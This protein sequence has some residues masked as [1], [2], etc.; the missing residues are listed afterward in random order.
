[1]LRRFAAD[2]LR[3]APTPVDAMPAD[4][5]ERPVA[6]RVNRLGKRYDLYA[7]PSDRLRQFIVPRLQ[8]LLRAQIRSY[9]R[10]V[11]A[12]RDV[13]FDVRR[14]DA[15]GIIG[16]NGS[17]KSTLLQ[18]VTGVLAPTEGSVETH[19]RVAALLELG[20]GFNPDFTGRENVHLNGQ[21]LGLTHAEL[22]ARFDDIAAFAD[23]GH[24]IDQPVK[25][26]SSGMFVRLA[27]AVVAHVRA[28]ILVVDEA[29]SVGDV[30]FGQKCM[31]FLRSFREQGGTLFFVSHDA[32][33]VINLCD[34]AVWLEGGR[35]VDIGDP[36]TLCR[37]YIKQAYREREQWV[38][39]LAA[40]TQ[41]ADAGTTAPAKARRPNTPL[42]GIPL[43]REFWARERRANPI[44]VSAFNRSSDAYG[45]YG[46]QIE[47]VAFFNESGERQGVVMGG[48]EVTFSIFATAHR[49]IEFPAAGIVIRDRLGQA[50]FTEGTTL[51]FAGAYEEEGLRFEPGDRVRVDFHFVMPILSEG[52]YSISVAVA[53][54]FGHDHVQHH[55]IHD[56]LALTA[57]ASPLLHG[58]A[59]F[60]GARMRIALYRE[61]EHG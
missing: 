33:A 12:L 13:S 9:G 50:V 51:A 14:G 61:E 49:L 6:L 59:G 48:E 43:R 57:L 42:G 17:G 19:G 45:L 11:W 38:D 16:R 46:V 53:E 18:L 31:R 41:S 28:D 24:Y 10:A 55:L 44:S 25:T 5:H 32:S 56:A 22:V 23:I 8:R 34:R 1:M 27:F 26:Y 2:G 52:A 7:R 40:G 15:V 60:A 39:H 20:S 54:G 35:V 29:L 21:V 37:R 4:M 47:D 58:I 3:R 30:F 36:E